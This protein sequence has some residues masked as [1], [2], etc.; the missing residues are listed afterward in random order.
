[1]STPA[2]AIIPIITRGIIPAPEVP[3]YN[4]P[5]MLVMTNIMPTV[6]QKVPFL[7]I[8]LQMQQSFIK[9]S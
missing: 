3:M 4:V 7:F 8:K 5:I 9:L 1:M 6:A 2:S